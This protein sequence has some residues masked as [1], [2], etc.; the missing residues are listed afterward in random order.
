MRALLLDFDGLILDTETTDFESWAAIYRE[1]GT[2]LP[3]DRWVE[4]IGSDGSGF[5]PFAHLRE[6][7]GLDLDENEVR[8]RHRPRRDAMVAALRPLPGVLDWIQAARDREMGVAIVSSSPTDWVERHLENV[9]MDLLFDFLMTF[10]RVD[11]A[12]PHPQLYQ[13]ALSEY[14][15][16]AGD[17][18]AVEDSPHGVSA[19]KAAGIFCVAVP[20]PMTCHLSFEAADEV[21]DSLASRS[22]EAVVEGRA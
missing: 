13:R 15:F 4:T 6:L 8:S 1:Y 22:L 10:D 16:G 14:G 18:I 20:G 21:L 3:R 19:A 2:E 11:H 17:A 9:A 5:A 12:K 7:T